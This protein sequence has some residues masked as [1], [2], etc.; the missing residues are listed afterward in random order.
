M[1]M[2]RS[3]EEN[4]VLAHKKTYFKWKCILPL[5]EFH[6]NILQDKDLQV[7]KRN[8]QKYCQDSIFVHNAK[9]NGFTTIKNA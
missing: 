5:Q 6:F 7:T 9:M 1:Q 3:E 4:A 8:L 2:K